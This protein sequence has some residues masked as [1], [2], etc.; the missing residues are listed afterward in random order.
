[1]GGGRNW[2]LCGVNGIDIGKTRWDDA[3]ISEKETHMIKP[4]SFLQRM[5]TAMLMDLEDEIRRLGYGQSESLVEWLKERGVNTSKSAVAR[6]EL[7]LKASDGVSGSAG[8]MRA[9]ANGNGASLDS[10][11]GLYRR[12]GEL[13]Y[14]REMIIGMIRDKLAESED[15][16]AQ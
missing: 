4:R 14:E 15:V 8:S 16:G 5:P 9:I 6:Y 11:T 12:L 13:D 1:M 10:I 3:G 7:A 2:D